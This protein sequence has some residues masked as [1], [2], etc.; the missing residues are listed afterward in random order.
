MSTQRFL[1]NFT[2][3]QTDY[4]G[5][6]CQNI[7]ENASKNGISAAELIKKNATRVT[8]L[9]D[10]RKQTSQT[11]GAFQENGTSADFV[12]ILSSFERQLEILDD[13]ALYLALVN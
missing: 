9:G 4:R 13:I 6:H 10:S 2:P 12:P 11:I 7:F 1:P 8:S 5:V 3:S